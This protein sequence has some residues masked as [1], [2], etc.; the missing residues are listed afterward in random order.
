MQYSVE[1]ILVRW[2]NCWG[3]DRIGTEY[4]SVTP[5]IPVLPSKPRKAWLK[6]LSDEECLK[7]EGAIM[8]LHGVDLLAYRVTMAV[9]IQDLSEKDITTALNISPS[10]MYRLRNRGIAFLQGA[11]S[12]LKIK[13]HYIG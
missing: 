3:R 10:K 11:F 8:A 1:K 12:M 4:P 7:I 9:Y 2:G 13:Y 6:H 5:S